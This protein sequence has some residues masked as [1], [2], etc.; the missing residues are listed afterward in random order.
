MKI[1]LAIDLMQGRVVRLIKGDPKRMIIY[2]NDPLSVA[3][4]LERYGD[5][6]HII[7]LDATLALGNNKDVIKSIAENTEI[8][9]EV[10][11]GIRSIDYAMEMLDYADH[12]IIGTLAYKDKDALRELLDYAR[13]RIIIALDHKDGKVMMEGWMSNT[14]LDLISSIREF[15]T[16]QVDKFLVTNIERDGTLE[17][18][19][20]ETY[21]KIADMAKIIASGGITSI[22]DL[23][24]L[25]RIGIYGAI[26]GKAIYDNMLRLEDV[27]SI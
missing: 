8:E 10:G 14:D 21:R 27:K 18:A 20:L 12:I 23:I 2:S 13:D 7:D 6:L 4:N 9:I 17:G 19:D 25:K 1:I 26:L 11:G 3:K 15:K 16:M 5:A 24:S 22:D